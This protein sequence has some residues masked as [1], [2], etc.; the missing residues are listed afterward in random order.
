MRGSGPR[1]WPRD[2]LHYGESK[3]L[4]RMGGSGGKGVQVEKRC[5][6]GVSQVSVTVGP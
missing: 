5:I 6:D 3:W 1:G 2:S 4:N